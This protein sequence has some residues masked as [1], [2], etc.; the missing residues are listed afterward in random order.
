MNIIMWK[1]QRGS[2]QYDI[3]CALIV[4]FILFTPRRFFQGTFERSRVVLQETDGAPTADRS[5]GTPVGSDKR[6]DDDGR[7][8]GTGNER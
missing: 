2:W 4:A 1:F 6:S 7:R 3:M 8:L 5:A